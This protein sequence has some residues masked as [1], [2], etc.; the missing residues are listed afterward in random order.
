VTSVGDSGVTVS[1][2]TSSTSIPF[3]SAIMVEG[4]SSLLDPPGPPSRASARTRSTPPSGPVDEGIFA[5]LKAWRLERSKSDGV[6][7]FVVADNKTLEAITADM[8]TD[9]RSLL[10]VSGIGPT[11]L[12]LYG[13]EILAILD[14]LRD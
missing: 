5:A 2:G 11:K 8:P 1:I 10:A 14:Q 13:D 4:R 6:P 9:Q 7:A 3:G 12:E